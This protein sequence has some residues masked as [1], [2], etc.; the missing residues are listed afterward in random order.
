MRKELDRQ[1]LVT[2]KVDQENF[3]WIDEGR[4]M[5]IGGRMF[6]VKSFELENGVYTVN[7]LFDDEETA[8]LKRMQENREDETSNGNNVLA[9]FFGLEGTNDQQLGDDLPIY[10]T[11]KLYPS[12][13]T[14]TSI[15]HVAIITP[16]PRC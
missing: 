1:S 16:P 14:S 12:Y 11:R 8:L 5:M 10:T 15:K 9:E 4:E 7:G 3:S 6:D 13:I 2:I